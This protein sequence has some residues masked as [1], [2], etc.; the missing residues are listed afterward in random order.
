MY[1][2]HGILGLF[3]LLVIALV[4]KP[5]VLFN[6]H[7]NILGRVLLIGIVL[8]FTMFNV[9]L[10]L[11]SALCLI[12]ASNMFFMEGMDNIDSSMIQ[13]GLTIGDDNTPST[14]SVS[15]LSKDKVRSAAETKVDGSN[16]SGATIS[17]L[18]EQAQAQGVDKES[19]RSSIEAKNSKSMPTNKS[20]FRSEDVGAS[21]SFVS[22]YS[23]F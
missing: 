7:R 14:G 16:G 3:L 12:I 8:F 19:I 11:L 17:E 15:V 6:L 4:L 23:K 9:T 20:V 22:S 10:G 2:K 1:E 5:R 18:Q 21:E 13:P